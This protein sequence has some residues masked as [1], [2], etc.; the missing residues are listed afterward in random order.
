MPTLR[1]SIA[2][3]AMLLI[4]GCSGSQQ[5]RM[6]LGSIP[7]P[8]PFTLFA[9]ADPSALGNHRYESYWDSPGDSGPDETPRGILYT[10]RAGFLDLSHIR[11]SMD[12]V[13]YAHDQL[14]PGMLACAAGKS[15]HAQ[16]EVEWS[17]CT[18]HVE[19]KVPDWW[20]SLD[21]CERCAI[22]KEAAMLESERLAVIVG[23]WHE[24]ATWWGQE[25]VP[26]FSEK[27]SALTWDDTTSHVV[28]AIVAGRALR[29]PDRK[30][31]QAVTQHLDD[32]L[33]E[34]GVVNSDTMER[35]VQMVHGRWWWG[36]V[37]IRR[38]LDVGLATDSKMPW[39]V[40]NLDVCP[41]EIAQPLPVPNLADVHG[42][43][44][45]SAFALRLCP[46]HW[47]LRRGLGSASCPYEI[48][49]EQEIL[50]AIEHLRIALK[51]EFG[52]DADNPAAPPSHA[53]S[54]GGV[55]ARPFEMPQAN[56]ER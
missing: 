34:L 26:P 1:L 28:A 27:A 50:T 6:R 17:D 10:C 2:L 56:F 33:N 55:G 47:V 39:T 20:S 37:A 42:H 44:L 46:Q 23:T 16:C 11:E 13:K 52:P 54:D 4:T 40:P 24:I 43:D 41:G 3:A 12:I 22:A 8:G 21:E 51:D 32:E 38:D 18:Y 53:I 5:P 45:R 14:A 35:A 36:G 9:V 30:W 29:D 19:F 48:T 7:F 15:D 25:T 49:S 31:N